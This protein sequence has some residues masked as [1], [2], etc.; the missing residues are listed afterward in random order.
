M[1]GYDA[2]FF[3]GRDDAEIVSHAL[4][5]G[6]IILTRD[7]HLMDWGVIKSGRIKA[8]LLQSDNP[9]QQMLQLVRDLTIEFSR[10]LTV[11]L[12]CNEPLQM[13]EKSEVKE[14]VPPYVYSKH[15]EFMQCP[16]CHRIYWR[17]S[18][19]RAMTKKLEGLA[20]AQL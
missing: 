4:A 14:K 2:L 13:V 16:N 19:W 20:G 9:D 18:H 1:V 10:Q 3:D 8:V 7:T 5:E 17:G 6:R 15:N 11:C 12:E